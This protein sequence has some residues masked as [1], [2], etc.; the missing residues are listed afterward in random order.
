MILAHKIRLNPTP[1]QEC[2]F[3]KAAGVARF[4]YNWGLG[5]WNKQRREGGEP[6]ILELKKHFNAIKRE[7]F[8]FVMEV[9]K[10]AAQQP[11]SDLA[12][13]FSRFFREAK[14]K[15]AK[16]GYPKFKSKKHNRPS[17][18]LGNDQFWVTKNWL[19]VPR[20]G[21]VNMAE[22]LRFVGKIM[23]GRVTK[24][25]NHWFVSIQVEVERPLVVSNGGECVGIDMGVTT[26]MTLSDESVVENQKYAFV[27][28]ARLQKLN[29]KLSRQCEGSSNWWKTVCKLRSLY[30]KIS[31][32][33][34]DH[35]HK[36]TTRISKS[37][38]LIGLEDLNAKAMTQNRRLGKYITDASFGEIARQFDYK[39]RLY[40]SHVVRVNRFY[41]SSKTCS[42]CGW[43]NSNLTLGNRKFVC[44]ECGV[45]KG[46]DINAA[47]NIRNKALEL[48]SNEVSAG[49]GYISVT[50]VDALASSR[51]SEAGTKAYHKYVFG[52][53]EGGRQKT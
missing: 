44:K 49:N 45:V 33:R 39:Q 52:S 15:S 31:N 34:N 21:L 11:F 2:Y 32:L 13:A 18:Y 9:T 1:E 30:E 8:P 16:V 43:Y 25:G 6:S 35:L 53:R 42:S 28:R 19:R 22:E 3:R 47:I 5:E 7:Q 51:V 41:P 14:N 40:G 24:R 20:L 50:P 26:L 29:R 4:T 17:F 46:R 12:T 36:H 37:Y 27:Y 10:Y 48:A 23:N 38:S